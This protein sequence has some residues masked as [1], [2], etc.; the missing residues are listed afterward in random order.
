EENSIDLKDMVMDNIILSMP[1]KFLC[2]PECR[3][4]CP[5]CGKN[6]N[7]YQCNCNKNNV[8]PRL[9][10]LKDLFKGD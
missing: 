8:D 5:V 2:S 1:I 7:K 10:V 4:L 9:A 3:G 6:L